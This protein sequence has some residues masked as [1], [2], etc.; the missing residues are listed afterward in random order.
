MILALDAGNTNICVGCIEDGAV[1]LTARIATDRHKT[2]D[3]YAGLLEAV[4]R[5]NGVGLDKLEGAAVCSV[6]PPV[7]RCLSLAVEMVTGRTPF[8]VRPGI[9]TGLTLKV[10]N[11]DLLGSDRI[12][13]AAAAACLYGGPVIVVDMGTMTTLSVVNSKNEFL[14][15][16]ICPGIRL[17]QQALAEGTSQLPAVGLDPPKR[18]IGRN[19]ADCIK[20]GVIFG[21]AA[22]VDGL[23]AG[24]RAELLGMGEP[25]PQVVMTGGISKFV[26]P[27]CREPVKAD[28]DLLL[29]GLWLLYQKNAGRKEGRA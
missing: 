21:T 7:N 3:E 6:V 25:A 19:T 13:D 1:L 5:L 17:S 23:I 27:Y 18:A 28:P 26:A 20:S 10:D 14:G 2:E 9:E 29:K 12:A 22:T 24:I 15:G 11:P 4:L 16:A 8:F